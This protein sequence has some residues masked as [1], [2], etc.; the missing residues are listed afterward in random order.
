MFD[1]DFWK[2]AEIISI[3]TDTDAIEDGVLVD[4]A[5]HNIPFNGKIINRVT[6]GVWSL[7]EMAE[8]DSAILK[9]RLQFIS[10]NSKKDRE[11]SDAWGIFEAHPHLGNAKFWLVGNEIGGYSLMLPSEY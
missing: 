8:M 11:D 2:D 1:N 10:G 4:V 7:L 6:A 9:N 3:Y 5:V